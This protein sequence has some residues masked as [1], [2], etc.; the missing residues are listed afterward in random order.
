LKRSIFIIAALT[1]LLGACG[2]N[3]IPTVSSEQIQETAAVMAG[4]MSAQTQ[5]AIPPTS[6][7]TNTPLPSPTSLPTSTETPV[8]TAEASST[9]VADPCSGSLYANPVGASDAGKM[10]NGASIFIVNTTKAPVTISLFLAKNKFGQCG[11]VSW[12]LSPKQSI[13]IVNQ[14]PYGCYSAFAYVND[15]K[16]PSHGSGGPDCITGPDRTTF[17]V[18]ADKVR[19][20]G[21]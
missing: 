6:T 17:T 5:A 11:Y 4:T 8:P 14:L 15:P 18:L 12:S 13:S 21:P 1:L 9:T 7:L 10:N 16:N 3:A 19:I 20:T 2:A